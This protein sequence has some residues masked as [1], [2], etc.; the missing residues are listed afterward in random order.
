MYE[1]QFRGKGGCERAACVAVLLEYM[2]AVRLWNPDDSIRIIFD[3][4]EEFK[5]QIFHIDYKLPAGTKIFKI[6]RTYIFLTIKF[7]KLEDIAAMQFDSHN[8]HAV[9]T[10]VDKLNIL[11]QVTP[12]ELKEKVEQFV[13]LAK[14]ITHHNQSGLLIRMR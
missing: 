9:Q 8:R 1:I 12:N 4:Q 5:S 2:G 6:F 10:L 7:N 14:S 11:Q 13:D 3:A